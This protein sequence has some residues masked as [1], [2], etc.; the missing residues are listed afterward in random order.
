LKAGIDNWRWSGVPFYLRTGKRLPQR[1]S[2][3]VVQFRAPPHLIYPPSAESLYPNRLLMRLQPN[4]GVRLFMLNKQPGPGDLR[5]RQLPLDLSFA[6]AFGMK[7][8]DAYERLLLDVIRG[9]ST[10]FMRVDELEAAWRWTDA[11]HEGWEH[12]SVPVK[13]YAAG[14]WGP[15]TAVALIERDGRTW[16]EEDSP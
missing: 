16:Y 6:E 1:S 7:I 11:I 8:P 2:E 13:P 14:T 5:L 15:T 12:W 3:I 9:R 10:L 4:E